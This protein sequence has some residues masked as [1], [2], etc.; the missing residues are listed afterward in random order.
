[1]QSQAAP[2]RASCS[3]ALLQFLLDYPLGEGPACLP[4]G[5]MGEAGLLQRQLTAATP[6]PGSFSIPGI[7]WFV[8][9]CALGFNT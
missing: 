1:M 4:G 3:S 5:V 8:C 6:P 9:T 7:S 2:V